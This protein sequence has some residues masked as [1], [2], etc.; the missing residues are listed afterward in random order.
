MTTRRGTAAVAWAAAAVA[1]GL[2]GAAT[3]LEVSGPATGGEQGPVKPV[4]LTAVWVVPGVLIARARPRGP[5]GWLA[6]GEALLF[7]AAAFGD[8][9]VR[10]EDPEAGTGVAWAAWVTDR[11]SALLVVGL[12]LLLVLLPDGRLPSR[13][14]RP[15]VGAVLGVQSAAVVAFATVQ[16][17]AAAPDTSLPAS[18]REVA[19][20]VGLLPESVGPALDGLDA[21]L[22]QLPLL[23]C[24]AA[25]GVRLRRA[26]TDERVRVVGVLLAASTFVLLV[27]VGHAFWPQMADTLDVL[28][29]GLL[30][31]QLTAAVL[32]RPRV[33]AGAVRATFVATVLASTVAG[34][35]VALA[36]LLA[37]WGAS[38]P[39]YGIAVVAVL[40]TLA[41]QPLRSRLVRLVD[42]LL[43]GDVRDPYRALQRLAESTHRAPSTAGVLDGLAATVGVSLRVPWCRVDVPGGS[44]SWGTR[45]AGGT[46]ARADLVSGN[47]HVGAVTVA[48]GPGRRLHADELRL[49]AEL[50]RHGGVAVQAALLTAELRAGRHRLVVAREEERR[51]LRRDLH[52]QIGP[53]LAGISMQLGAVRPLV[54]TDPAA[55]EDRL[56]RLQDAARGALEDVRRVAHGLRPP[57]LD[58]LGL[59]GALR[60]LADSLG[61]DARFP[62]PDPPRLAAAVE[63]A[64]YRI[65]AEAL[66]NVARHAGTA[67]VEVSIREGHGEMVLRVR[68]GGT[69]LLP[70]RLAGVG[71]VAMRERVDEL[72][73]TLVI[74]SAPG[75]GTTVTARLPAAVAAPEVVA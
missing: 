3:W 40:L 18:A 66:H 52:D 74:D 5:L 34:L 16:G 28:A 62:D 26:G 22:L 14:W 48:A 69:G 37:R 32:G 13:R 39:N 61:L 1:L 21:L 44:G 35:A 64:G 15:A 4:L 54:V 58:G 20:P 27:V 12:G 56:V 71:L 29:A 10:S 9:W 38:L 42:R 70:D 53:T 67:V 75:A 25:Y 36:A 55:A 47:A 45:P 6:L 72:G 51:R 68:D 63:V 57:A 33:V 43:F 65:G 31:A 23:L 24:L 30:A 46:E 73:G 8:R 19:N 41:V 2:A 11:A 7:A 60:Q 59:A 17:P 50:G 49:L